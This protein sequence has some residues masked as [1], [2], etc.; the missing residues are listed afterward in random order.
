MIERTGCVVVGGGPAGMVLGLL[1][2]RA[3]VAVTVLEKHG[4]FLRDFRGDTVHPSTLQLLDE[5]GLGQQFAELSQSRL[6]E[7]AFPTADGEYLTF[8][9]F[10]RLPVPHPYIAMVP[11]WDLLSLLAGAAAEEECFT[12]RMDTEV[13]DLVREDGVV[14]GVRC[15]NRKTGLESELRAELTVGADGRTSRVREAMKMRTKESKVP[16]DA[17]WLR[18]PRRPGDDVASLRP[19]SNFGHV[20][21]AIPRPDYFQI[22][23]FAPK[24]SDAEIRKAGL[25]AFR[26]RIVDC[27]PQLADRVD[28]LESMDDVKHLDVRL[29][30]LQKWHSPGVLCIGDAA[31]AMSPVAGVGINLAIQDAVAT[32]RLLATPLRSGGLRTRDLARVRRRRRLATVLSQGLQM[33]LHRNV[34]E[35]VLTRQR[36]GPPKLAIWLMRC[37][38]QASFVPAYLIGVG[39]RAEHAPE[40]ARR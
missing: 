4:D 6:G 36:I 35:P 12:L 27:L 1:L 38:P 9:D 39:V 13:T 20:A 33:A 40:F 31:H 10:K 34:V 18:L 17:W 7:I 26:D 23:Y 11:Q 14:V 16:F 22:A 8:V 24:G 29:N 32:A 15:R 37:V 30:R 3:G 28:H 25:A 5:L 19:N 21:V 2:A